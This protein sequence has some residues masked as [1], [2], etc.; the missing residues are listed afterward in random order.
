MKLDLSP[1]TGLAKTADKIIGRFRPSLEEKSKAQLDQYNAE[2]HRMEVTKDE[3]LAEH[4]E[5][6][7]R[8]KIE[9][10][11]AQSKEAAKIRPMI[12]K[13]CIWGIFVSLLPPAVQIIIWTIVK[14][15]LV[16]QGEASTIQFDDAPTM[17][18]TQLMTLLG[19][20]IGQGTLRT[21]EKV[22]NVEGN[23]N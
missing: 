20:S 6:M 14:F 3:R 5:R 19:A 4:A 7:Q 8:L 10:S 12:G 11:L 18:I 9:Q 15:T 23:R 1:W 13:V 17:D 21:I 16:I 2:T 22:K